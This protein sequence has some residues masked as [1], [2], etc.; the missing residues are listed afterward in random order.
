MVSYLNR[1]VPGRSR[2]NAGVSFFEGMT[3]QQSGNLLIHLGIS[4]S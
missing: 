1:K 3:N 4:R 2:H